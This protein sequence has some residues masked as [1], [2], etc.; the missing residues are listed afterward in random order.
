M[1]PIWRLTYDQHKISGGLR[2]TYQQLKISNSDN[3]LR[4]K[5]IAFLVEKET[6]AQIFLPNIKCRTRYPLNKFIE[7]A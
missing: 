5:L 7:A 2:N 3:P 6:A 1:L 4:K